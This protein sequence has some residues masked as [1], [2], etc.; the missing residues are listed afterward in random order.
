MWAFPGCGEQGLL[1][2][3]V[4]G[5]LTVVT[6]L[7]RSTG[8][9]VHRFKLLLPMGSVVGTQRLQSSDSVAVALWQARS[10]WA[11]D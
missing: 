1:L 5:L 10:S 9:R 7:V 2:I 8:S 6:S 4:L 3:V 11:R